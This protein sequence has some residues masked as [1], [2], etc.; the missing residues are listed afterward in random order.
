M[1][2]IDNDLGN[3]SGECHLVYDNNNNKLHNIYIQNDAIHK[4]WN[5][6]LQKFEIV[7]VFVLI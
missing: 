7:H 4:I 1:A 3:G 5:E 2:Q 6:I